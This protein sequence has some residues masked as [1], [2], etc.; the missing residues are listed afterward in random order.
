MVVPDPNDWAALFPKPP[1]LPRPLRI[2]LPCCGID[3]CGTALRALGVD[4]HA[5]NV[6]DIE[7]RYADFLKSHFDPPADGF[8][9]GADGDVTTFSVGDLSVHGPVDLLISG[10]PCPPWSSCG[11][12]GGTDDTRAEVFGTVL[13]WMVTWI[14]Q[15]WL[16]GS[17]LENVMGTVQGDEAF[18]VRVRNTLESEVPAFKWEINVLHAKDYLLAQNRTRAFLRGMRVDWCGPSLPPIVPALGTRPL[19]EFLDPEA[20]HTPASELSVGM[21]RNLVLLEKKVLADRQ[22]GLLEGTD[23]VIGQVDR[24]Q[25]KRYLS[26]YMKNICYTLTTANRYLFVLSV[27]DVERPRAT[28]R[29]C[30]FLKP[31]ERLALQGF[32][33]S[34]AD[35]LGEALSVKAAGNAY[36]VPLLA[37]CLQ[38]VICALAR[39]LGG[40]AQ[41]LSRWPASPP[42]HVDDA[43]AAQI[44][45]RL[46]W[47]DAPVKKRPA[48]RG[49]ACKTPKRAKAKKHT[50]ARKGAKGAKVDRVVARRKGERK[51]VARSTFAPSSS[52]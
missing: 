27:Q 44:V 1:S 14:Q 13:R 25:H 9:I 16:I 24:D 35:V 36:P 8:H 21:R 12:R 7:G 48:S 23:V 30:R 50:K 38:P 34:L 41:S 29:F 6:F 33:S 11:K 19:E 52:S 42:E 45:N 3:G 22:S 31:G 4:F 51:L 5:C 43:L 47:E 10:P 28:R 40:D 2:A 46:L 32:P 17:V 39:G 37:A 49:S 15:G 26:G 18:M 20:P